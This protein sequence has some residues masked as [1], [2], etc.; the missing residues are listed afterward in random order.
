MPPGVPPTPE[1]AAKLTPDPLLALTS[2]PRELAAAEAIAAVYNMLVNMVAT[3]SSAHNVVAIYA[4]GAM[5]FG[6]VYGASRTRYRAW[7]GRQPPEVVSG[8][9]RLVVDRE[10]V[11]WVRPSRIRSALRN[12]WA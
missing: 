3:H 7:V 11:S 9:L 6:R 5:S 8:V 12:Y 1:T 10:P 4:A 2:D